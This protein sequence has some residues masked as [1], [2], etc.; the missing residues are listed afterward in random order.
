M[1]SRFTILILAIVLLIFSACRKDKKSED[2]QQNHR[3]SITTDNK[4]QTPEAPAESAN[5]EINEYFETFIAKNGNNEFIVNIEKPKMNSQLL[6]KAEKVK[7]EINGYWVNDSKKSMVT[8][9]VYPNSFSANNDNRAIIKQK[10]KLT[11]E[12]R[13]LIFNYLNMLT[14]EEGL[15][16]YFLKDGKDAIYTG[17]FM[18]K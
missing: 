7:L 11:R 13:F 12:N 8:L 14:L 16:Y 18:V 9:E 4:P 2:E 17:K 10:L 3:I 1:N 15:Y 5:F 6:R